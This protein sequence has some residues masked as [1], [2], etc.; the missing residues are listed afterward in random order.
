MPD[1][2]RAQVEPMLEIVQ[3]LGFPMLRVSGAGA[4]V[5][6][7]ADLCGWS[8]TSMRALKRARRSAMP[9]ARPPLGM[10]PA[11]FLRDYWQK[12]AGL[13]APSNATAS[14]LRAEETSGEQGC[15]VASL[16][17]PET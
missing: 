3:A 15:R 8:S 2:L 9:T 12:A 14:I 17:W 5:R 16:P 7:P 1:D 13:L 11:E 10:P 4:P 6:K